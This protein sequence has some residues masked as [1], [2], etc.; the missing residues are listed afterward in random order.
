[1]QIAD[2]FAMALSYL[3]SEGKF[4]KYCDKHEYDYH[5]INAKK[6]YKACRAEYCKISIVFSDQEIADM[7]TACHNEGI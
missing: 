2:R 1:M 4:Y 5:D 7:F 3:Q 6:A